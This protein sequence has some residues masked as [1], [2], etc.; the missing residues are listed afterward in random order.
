ME[1][2]IQELVQD[3]HPER[4]ARMIA[5]AEQA[6][7]R[8]ADAEQAAL[9]LAERTVLEATVLLS[10]ANEWWAHNLRGEHTATLCAAAM[11]AMRSCRPLSAGGKSIA[12]SL[13]QVGRPDGG[14]GCHQERADAHEVVHGSGGLWGP[15][16]LL[17]R[18]ALGSAD[19]DRLGDIVS[20]DWAFACTQPAM[21]RLCAGV[22]QFYACLGML[23]AWREL[24]GR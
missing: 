13:L 7:K 8:S 5:D 17:E 20:S 19:T 12:A 9:R 22:V 21:R 4:S 11:T 16:R 6:A 24:V 15:S 14:Q 10:K 18:D 23:L 3:G 2:R 1:A